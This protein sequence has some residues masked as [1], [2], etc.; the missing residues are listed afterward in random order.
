VHCGRTAGSTKDLAQATA[1]LFAAA[2]QVLMAR[3]LSD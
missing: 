2:E 1:D 3:E